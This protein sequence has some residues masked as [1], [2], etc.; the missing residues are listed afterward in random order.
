MPRRM[1][2]RRIALALALASTG[3]FM[4][5]CEAG[6]DKPQVREGLD[7]VVGGVGYN[8]YITRQLN[9]KQA[10]DNDFYQGPDAPR[11]FA[12]YAIFIKACNVTKGTKM[13]AERYVVEDT[14][15]NEYEPL[16]LPK[17]NRFAFRPM[18]L[19]YTQCIPEPGSARAFNPTGG[20]ML[21]YNL[22]V[23]AQENRPLE[24]QIIGT[25]DASKG[26]QPQRTIELDI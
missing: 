25:Y 5:G 12:L 21:L 11:G 1:S 4:A 16:E 15:G 3:V 8:V 7:V 13:P 9:V 10:P 14:R 17:T 2:L 26:E 19:Q 6:G 20:A 24:L 23:S 22:P 18:P